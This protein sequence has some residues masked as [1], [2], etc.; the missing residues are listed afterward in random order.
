MSTAASGSTRTGPARLPALDALRAV[1]A[2]GVLAYHV[3]FDTGISLHGTWN[4]LLARL[5]LG[6]AV[7]FVLSGFLLFRP[8]AHARATG[9]ER[10]GT[11]RY[12]WRR[13][14]RILPAYWLA[15]VVCLTVLPL[16]SGAGWVEWTHSLTLT[17]IYVPDQLHHGLTQTWSLATEMAFYLVLPLAAIVALG[18]R[19][20]PGRTVLICLLSIVIT[21]GWIT[22]LGF[23]GTKMYTMWL[24]SYAFWFGVG[25]AFAAVHVA[26]ATG[27]APP[28][29]RLVDDLAAAPLACWG[30]ALGLLAIVS[31]P[32]AGPR[33]LAAP[34]ALE[35]ATKNLMFVMIASLI[36]LPLAFG[37]DNRIKAAFSGD[38]ARWLGAISYGIFLWHPFVIDATF[39]VTG[40][41]EF[42][43]GYL[44]L[45]IVALV[46]AIV[47]ASLS[48]YAMELP[49]QRWGV[50][51]V[52]R[53]RRTATESHSAVAVASATS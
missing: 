6:V 25:M 8:F 50:R 42:S 2:V 40:W 30:L 9:A 33:D 37:P 19:W 49:L 11:G 44:R 22:T 21:A 28:R 26:L 16:N 10:P 4:G 41:P 29:W 35:F 43:G 20:R 36:L 51:R 32:L 39:L 38:L 23:I 17:Q 3:G 1:G 15:V 5:D 31:T 53:R 18:R 47:L 48:Y 34:T 52:P 7:F 14:L 24:P 27:T 13:A 12:L 46:G 45:L